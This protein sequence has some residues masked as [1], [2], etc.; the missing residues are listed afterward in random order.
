V[1]R[2]SRAAGRVT[3]ATMNINDGCEI[4]AQIDFKNKEIDPAEREDYLCFL[5][6]QMSAAHRVKYPGGRAIRYSLTAKGETYFD[7]MAGQHD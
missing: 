7:Q 1:R 4:I 5:R 6:G 2:A 3:G